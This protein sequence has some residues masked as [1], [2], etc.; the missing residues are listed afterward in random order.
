MAVITPGGASPKP[1]ARAAWSPISPSASFLT[2]E[3]EFFRRDDPAPAA[4]LSMQKNFLK[5]RIYD[6]LISVGSGQSGLVALIVVLRKSAGGTLRT[7]VYV[8]Y[9]QA[10]TQDGWQEFFT[11]NARNQLKSPASKT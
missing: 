7:Y 10:R 9:T 3:F 11:P 8:K 4:E 6:M 2:F 5:Y 1:R